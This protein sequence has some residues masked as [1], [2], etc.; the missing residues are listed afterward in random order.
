MYIW[1]LSFPLCQRRLTFARL[2]ARRSTV[3]LQFYTL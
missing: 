3:V 1:L 2:E